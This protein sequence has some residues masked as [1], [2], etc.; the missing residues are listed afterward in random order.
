MYRKLERSEGKV[1]GIELEEEF[2]EADME[3]IESDLDAI[4]AE[5]GG[6]RLLARLTEGVPKP[7]LEALVEDVTY[8]IDHLDDVERYAVVAEGTPIE[9]VAEAENALFGADVR[10]FDPEEESAAWEWVEE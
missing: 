8:G 4:I 6:I 9:W 2:T 3:A 7:E 10:H 1:Y 5:H